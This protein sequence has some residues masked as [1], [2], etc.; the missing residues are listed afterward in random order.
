[1]ETEYK[2]SYTA[3]EIN[4]KLG[5]IDDY[6]V[7]EATKREL[8]GNVDDSITADTINGA[9]NFA[10]SLVSYD[11]TDTVTEQ[12]KIISVA[13][14]EVNSISVQCVSDSL[15]DFSTESVI[16]S[17]RNLLKNVAYDK[18]SNGISFTKNDNGVTVVGTASANAFY[19]PNENFYL[20]TGNY[21][22]SGCP[23]GG[24][25]TTYYVS[26][27]KVENGQTTLIGRDFGQGLE[28]TVPD[29]VVLKVFIG[30]VSG[31]EVNLN[32][33]PMIE[34]K[35][36]ATGVYETYTEIIY[37]VDSNGSV[38]DVEIV[39]PITVFRSN[40]KDVSLSISLTRKK[41]YINLLKNWMD[42]S[43]G[44]IENLFEQATSTP[45]ITFIDDDTTDLAAVQL[46]KNTCDELGIVGGFAV[47]TSNLDSQTDLAEALQ[48]YEKDGFHMCLHCDVHDR[49][50]YSE[51]RDLA[52]CKA[53]FVTGIRKMKEYN[54]VDPMFWCVPYGSMDENLESMAKKWGMNCA[55]TS[56]C[57]SYETAKALNGRF[58]LRRCSLEPTDDDALTSLD[59]LKQLVRM[60]VAENGWLLITTHFTEDGWADSQDRFR[61]LVNYAIAQGMQVKTLNEAF[62]MREP[63]YRLYESF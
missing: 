4:E 53:D 36:V 26:V 54:F 27:Q 14:N 47:V 6:G 32:F 15:T 13:K 3:A 37:S 24:S 41:S 22:L 52:Q 12:G 25:S 60:T 50:Y 46:Y 45:I 16:A 49:F 44:K 1:M 51:T 56:G 34:L 55:V 8:I 31:Q 20:P 40:N 18:T 33:K 2:L 63:I 23:E 17:G 43:Y 58:A 48:E 42:K 29:G 61:E 10:K 11:G 21:Y 59:R 62:R 57:N 28:F 9:K 19:Y 7:P 35:S 38:G 5:K 30:V 39:N